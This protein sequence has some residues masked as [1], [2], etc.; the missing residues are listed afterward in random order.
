MSRH[1][2]SRLVG[3]TDALDLQAAAD[4]LGV[5]YQTA[6]RWVRVGRLDAR[7]IGGRY[8]VERD[9]LAA[10]DKARRTP[11]ARTAPSAAR[12]DRSAD[13]FH[14]ALVNGDEKTVGKLTRKLVDEGSAMIDVTCGLFVPSLRRIGQAW[15]DGQ[16]AISTEHRAS[17][18]GERVLGE[19]MPNP[20]GRRRGTAMVTALSGDRHSLPTTMAA[21]V[22]REDNWHVHHLGSDMPADD[23]VD[24]CAV[25]DITLAAITVTMPDTADLAN[26]TADRLRAARTPTLVGEPG[27]TLGD[28][29]EQARH[30]ASANRR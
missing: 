13:R 17:A 22:L 26:A 6:Y 11:T 27:R 12:L 14:D 16:L 3:S 15:H 1:A 4:E 2:Y 28:L 24:F 5:H 8:V 29:V 21:V 23:I 7:M 25:H 30:A 19:F 10:L 9:D 20:R 18:I